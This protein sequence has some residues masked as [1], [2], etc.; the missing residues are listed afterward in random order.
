MSKTRIVSQDIGDATVLPDDL[1][2]SADNTTAD[3]TTGHHGLLPKLGGG[4]SNYLRADGTWNAPPG[5][6]SSV[7]ADTIWDAAGDLAVG[8]GSD[9]A[10]KLTAGTSGTILKS[11]GSADPTWAVAPTFHGVHAKKTASFPSL[12]DNVLTTLAFDDTD[13]YDTDALHDPS[14]NNTK[15]IVPS[16]LNGYW[17]PWVKISFAANAT[18]RRAVGPM[19]NGTLYFLDSRNAVVTAA[20]ATQLMITFPPIALVATDYIEFQAIQNSTGS[21]STTEQECGMYLMGT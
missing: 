21:L 16:G 20:K 5:T 19:K 14:S 7:A 12:T 10:H 3:A 15:L 4:S 11:A 9:T 6:G 1:D 17:V 13:T 18:G 2:V 8:T